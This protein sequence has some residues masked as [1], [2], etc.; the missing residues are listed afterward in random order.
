MKLEYSGGWYKLTSRQGRVT[1]TC[2]LASALAMCER[3]YK[4]FV[5][6]I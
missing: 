5:K 2:D 6:P 4:L 1:Y 3:Y